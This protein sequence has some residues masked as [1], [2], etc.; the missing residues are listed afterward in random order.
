MSEHKKLTVIFDFDGT[1]ADTIDLIIRVY[2]EH[3]DEFGSDR[4]VASE[5]PS[6]QKK[7]YKKAL[8]AKKL[9]WR[10]L[11]KLIMTVRREMIQHM[12][13]VKP[14]KGIKDV[15]EG[16]KYDGISIGILTSNDD[17]LVREFLESHNFPV[18]DFVV[19]EKT[20]FG[21]DKALKRIMERHELERSRVVYVGDEPRD[22]SA[23]KKAG[24]KVIGVTWG[25]GGVPG[26]ESS[27]PDVTVAT[28]TELKGAILEEAAR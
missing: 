19:S 16:L 15:L 10:V 23:S 8:K 6:L 1:L 28:V 7:G 12:H 27:R 2:N 3:A 21:K 9:R 20:I 25:L 14:Y 22:V 5:L 11:P 4:V 13:E 26:M 18:F 24:V 17:A